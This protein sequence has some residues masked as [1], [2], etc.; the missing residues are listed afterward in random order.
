MEFLGDSPTRT[1]SLPESVTRNHA[2][3]HLTKD[4]ELG[5]QV[6]NILPPGHSRIRLASESMNRYDE[7]SSSLT[8]LIQEEEISLVV[9][10]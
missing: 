4:R 2:L 3:T 8:T 10:W 1:Q 6:G 9:T 7:I 5:A